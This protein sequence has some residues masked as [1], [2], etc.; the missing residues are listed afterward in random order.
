ML[1]DFDI[2][3]GISDETIS[4]DVDDISHSENGLERENEDDDFFVDNIKL[5]TKKKTKQGKQ[6]RGRPKT[7]KKLNS[8]ENTKC[9][10]CD[11]V[12]KSEKHLG[13]HQRYHKEENESYSC[14]ICGKILTTKLRFY[15][16]K[17]THKIEHC[18]CEIC[19]KSFETRKSLTDH[20]YKHHRT[21][22][23]CKK[24]DLILANSKEYY[25]HIKNHE[26]EL[27]EENKSKTNMV[28]DE[29][30]VYKITSIITNEIND[31]NEEV[32]ETTYIEINP[33]QESQV[34]F[35]EI[36]NNISEDNK[37]ELENHIA[38]KH[39]TN[40]PCKHC[41]LLF[42][43]IQ[44]FRTHQ[45]S[46]H[47]ILHPTNYSCEICGKVLK[48]VE[49]LKLHLKNHN[50]NFTCNLC[51]IKFDLKQSYSAHMLNIHNVS[52]SVPEPRTP[53]EL[54]G[55]LVT[56]LRLK[57]H[58]KIHLVKFKCSTCSRNSFLLTIFISIIQLSFLL[59]VSVQ[60]LLFIKLYFLQF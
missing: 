24:C 35:K 49:N 51:D 55:K 43:D 37:N 5:E 30:K 8:K 18:Q 41:E 31:T 9:S 47:M 3:E 21:N 27:I 50:R 52:V 60:K 2:K 14:N 19:E 53:C 45:K 1:L 42:N 17:Q 58:M 44:S 13:W 11:K 38:T 34:E 40:I 15:A 10:I 25:I 4:F 48:S 39:I 26:N 20:I 22:I 32:Q 33:K 36:H 16:H 12:F 46:V 54:C 59:L 29:I 28:E 6:K 23:K 7:V 56:Q 57:K